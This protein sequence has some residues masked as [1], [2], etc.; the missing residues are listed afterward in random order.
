MTDIADTDDIMR[1]QQEKLTG[2]LARIFSDYTE[3][4]DINRET[5]HFASFINAAIFS[6]AAQDAG[7]SQ[8]ESN[9]RIHVFLSKFYPSD[10]LFNEA[11][12]RHSEYLPCF[13]TGLDS[14]NGFYCLSEAFA[15]K[16]QFAHDYTKITQVSLFLTSTVEPAI[17]ILSR[18]I[19]NKPNLNNTDAHITLTPQHDRIRQSAAK[20]MDTR[21]NHQKAG[22]CLTLL[23]CV[24]LLSLFIFLVF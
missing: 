23:L 21:H 5:I 17:I 15:N 16:I 3:N 2:Y 8:E 14:P 11:I 24:L 20:I 12:M 6:I 1:E 13:I 19:K 10:G 18:Q 7:I 9:A 22:G 4:H